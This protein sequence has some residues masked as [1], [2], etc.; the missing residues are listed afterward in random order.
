MSLS[1]SLMP[2]LT[3]YIATKLNVIR[4]S[5][6]S[7]PDFYSADFINL[8]RFFPLIID[9]NTGVWCIKL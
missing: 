3:P 5:D 6:P 7:R 8:L 9:T 4:L 1:K 2:R